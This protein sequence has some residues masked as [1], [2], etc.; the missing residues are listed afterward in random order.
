MSSCNSSTSP[1]LIYS[2][3]PSFSLYNKVFILP[4][5]NLL[6]LSNTS[7]IIYTIIR[8]I[9]SSIITPITHL[10][11]L[12]SFFSSYIIIIKSNKYLIISPIAKL[13]LFLSF[14]F[15]TSFNHIFNFNSTKPICSCNLV[16]VQSNVFTFKLFHSTTKNTSMIN[17]IFIINISFS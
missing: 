16:S 6:F 7:F 9:N 14:L 15:A 1:T 10:L 5:A 4:I 13:L 3:F 17:N 2:S 8:F 12:F 11:L